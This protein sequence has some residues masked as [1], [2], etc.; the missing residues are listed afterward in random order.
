MDYLLHEPLGMQLQYPSSCYSSSFVKIALLCVQKRNETSNENR[1]RVLLDTSKLRSDVFYPSA[2]RT[3]RRSMFTQSTC[4]DAVKLLPVYSAV[5]NKKNSRRCFPFC[6][7]LQSEVNFECSSIGA[8]SRERERESEGVG[9]LTCCRHG[10]K[11]IMLSI[12]VY[13]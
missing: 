1:K 9:L 5:Y 13:K 12:N 11:I 10:K 4:A 6:S 3:P 2:P 8:Q 7:L